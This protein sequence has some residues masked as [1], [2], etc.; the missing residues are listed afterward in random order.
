MW[1]E[2]VDPQ[3][4]IA[5]FNVEP[6]HTAKGHFALA[7]ALSRHG[8]TAGAAAAVRDSWRNDGFSEDLE[9]QAREVFAGLITPADD[10]ARMAA[11]LY[12]DDDDA[13]LRAAQHLDNAVAVAIAKARAAVINQ[14]G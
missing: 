14:S 3:A 1:Q 13:G 12:A 7:R 9:A 8:D 4:V 10:E 11:R 5:F 2:Q 6:P